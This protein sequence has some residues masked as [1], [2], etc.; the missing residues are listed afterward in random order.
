M[1]FNTP[2]DF[3]KYGL[4]WDITPVMTIMPRKFLESISTVKK[5]GNDITF[6][7]PNGEQVHIEL[8]EALG[9]GSFGETWAVKGPEPIAVKIMKGLEG[10]TLYDAFQECLVQILIYEATKDITIPENKLVGPF[11]PKFLLLGRDRDSIYIMMERIQ[12]NINDAIKKKPLS[13]FIKE[14]TLQ[15]CRILKILYEKL[16]YNHRDFKPDNIMY[17]IVDGNINVKLIDFGFSCLTYKNL[18]I[19]EINRNAYP[20]SLKSCNSETRDIHSYFFYLL[21]HS[22][23]ATV[24]CPVKKVIN[25]L[26]ASSQLKVEKWRNTYRYYNNENA[27]NSPNKPLNLSP[28]VVYNVFSKIVFSRNES[29]SEIMPE[30]TNGL[31]KLYPETPLFLNDAEISS[32]KPEVVSQ[33]FSNINERDLLGN[34]ALTYAVKNNKVHLVKWLLSSKKVKTALKDT[35]GKTCLHYAVVITNNAEFRK[36][37]FEIIKL[38]IAENPALP[39]I[40]DNSGAGP[41]NKKYALNAEVCDY[42]KT[43][44]STLF[45]SKKNTNRMKAGSYTKKNKL[46]ISQAR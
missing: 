5:T 17:N 41:A 43:R 9:A 24:E 28:D 31:V 46:K 44:K 1:S 13:N 15:I 27:G 19:R 14:S 32:I 3:S 12:F 16:K 38:L 26:I 2:V 37:A 4:N 40:K 8:A 10:N 20:S 45:S 33:F 18:R 21:K 22:Y 11:C 25:T 6:T 34:T 30:W 29:C 7:K 42:I 39:D 36:D 23:Y 35:Y